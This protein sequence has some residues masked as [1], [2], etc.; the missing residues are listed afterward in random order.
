MLSSPTKFQFDA[1]DGVAT[2]PLV[3]PAD[4][5]TPIRA[6]FRVDRPAGLSPI[7]WTSLPSK[8]AVS[9]RSDLTID[10]GTLT[11]T[12][13]VACDVTGGPADALH[14]NIPTDWAEGATL[15]IEGIPHRRVSERKG[16]NGEVT[17]WTILPESPIW[18][19]ARMVLRSKRPLQPGVQF[20]YPELSPLAAIGRGSVERYDLAIANVSGRPMEVS[21]SPGLQ[22]IDV[23][24]FRGQ[25]P[26]SPPG[27]I[28]HAYQVTGGRWWLRVRVGGSGDEPIGSGQG[29][30]TRVSLAQL[31][32]SLSEQG[33]L[34]GRARYDL[35]PRPAPFLAVRL[36]ESAEVLWAS[37]DGVIQPVVREGPSRWLVPLG[38]RN[39]RRVIVSWRAVGID[40]TAKNPLGLACPTL[41]QADVPTLVSVTAPESIQLGLS[42]SAAERLNRADWEAESADQARPQGRQRGSPDLD[43]SS[44]ARPSAD[45]R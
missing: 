18:G 35:E 13:A 43:R 36:A 37:V 8:V 16:T 42:S 45:P 10:P 5:D 19:R 12:A 14:W 15:E 7:R 39:P 4:P 6:S 30:T 34:F 22:P 3:G 27:S 23:A 17:L 9:V 1:G 21:G 2:L 26:A 31:T 32:C 24:R 25:E 40:S 44:P 33:E 11:W 28:D 29:L 41:D 38:D 20:N